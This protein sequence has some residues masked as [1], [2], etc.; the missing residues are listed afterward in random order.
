M[1]EYC[2]ETDIELTLRASPAPINL[3]APNASAPGQRSTI[4]YRTR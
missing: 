4:F 1:I 3:G 2:P